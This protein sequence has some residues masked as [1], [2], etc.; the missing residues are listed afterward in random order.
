MKLTG[1]Q[2]LAQQLVCEGVTQ[3][4]GIPGVQLDWAVDGLAGLNGAINYRVMRHEQAASYMADGYARSTGDP[5]VCMIVPGPGLLN[6]TAGLATA[7]ACSSPVLCLTG[8]IASNAIGKGYGLLHEI[9]DQSGIM[10]AVTKWNGFAHKPEQIPGLVREAFRQLRSGRPR[11]VGLEIPPDVLQ[12]SA[13]IDLI[14]PRDNGA[15]R[16]QPEASDIS[17]AAAIL[18]SAQRPIIYAGYGVQAADA[19]DE[20][21]RVAELLQ[22]PVVTSINGRG[23]ISDRHSLALTFTAGKNVFETADVVLVVGS[24]FMS[25]GAIP[26]HANPAVKYVYLNVEETEFTAPRKVDATILADAKLGLEALAAE[27]ADLPKR[28]SRSD[29]VL[30]AR[31]IA[32]SQVELIQPQ[33][34][35]LHALRTAIPDDGVLVN[36]MTQVGYISRVAYPVYQPRTFITQGYQGTLGAGYATALGVA[37]GNPGKAVVSING[38]GGFGFNMQELITAYRYNLGVVAVVFSDNAYG[39]VKRL[40]KMQFNRN[41][42]SDLV[43]PDWVKVADACNVPA[44]RVHTPDALQGAIQDALAAGGPALIEVPVGEMPN[45]MHLMTMK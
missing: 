35:F 20:L 11:P 24:R 27:L 43:N 5:G 12:A 22:A 37:A 32:D 18:K 36:E 10:A 13:E 16:T 33:A 3:I 40:Q 29:E 23:S 1:G 6:A 45:G 7:Y 31:A 41:L 14:D 19:T 26:V 2:A 25:G 38:D 34:A 4:F 42:G 9:K 17:R 8:H 30:K 39:N 21:V 15:G 44:Q 28:A